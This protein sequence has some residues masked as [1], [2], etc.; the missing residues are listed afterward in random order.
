MNDGKSVV[1]IKEAA[2]KAYPIPNKVIKFFYKVFEFFIAHMKMHYM[3][4]LLHPK[5]M[6]AVKRQF[7]RAISSCAY[8]VRKTYAERNRNRTRDDLVQSTEGNGTANVANHGVG[9]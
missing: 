6:E 2:S 3:Y 8:F 5:K 7:P 9:G 1:G 4:S